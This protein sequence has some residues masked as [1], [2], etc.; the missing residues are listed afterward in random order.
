MNTQH[1][2]ATRQ[3]KRQKGVR[4]NLT[5]IHKETGLMCIAEASMIS[6]NRITVQLTHK[7]L[8]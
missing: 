8:V 3:L 2:N 4:N 7:L 6:E 1:C 5:D